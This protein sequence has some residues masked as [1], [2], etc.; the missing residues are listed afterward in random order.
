MVLFVAAV[1]DAAVVVVVVA[2]VVVVVVV[3]SLLFSPAAPADVSFQSCAASYSSFVR[4]TVYSP[5]S[6]KA[7][8]RQN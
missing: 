5:A 3:A 1:V 8:A 4:L 2:D 7:T 6:K